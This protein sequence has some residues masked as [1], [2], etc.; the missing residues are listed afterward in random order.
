MARP[1]ANHFTM[2]NY[3]FLGIPVASFIILITIFSVL[4]T[5]AFIC[6]SLKIIRSR[7]HREEKSAVGLADRKQ[8]VS[9]LRS[10]ISSKALLMAKKMSW[11]K[12][13]DEGEEEG[14]DDDDDEEVVWKRTIIMGER[15]RPLDFSGKILYDSNGN[16]LPN[17]PLPSNG[18]GLAKL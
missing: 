10:S 7:R 11:R 3:A 15:C 4:S 5:V 9:W 14:I 17:S 8:T 12:V 18:N 16:P 6:I 2:Q 13:Q 1:L